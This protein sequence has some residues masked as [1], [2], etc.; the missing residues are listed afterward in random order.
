MLAKHQFPESQYQEYADQGYTILRGLI[1]KEQA[2]LLRQE[3]LDVV[4]ARNMPDSYLAQSHEYLVGSALDELNNGPELRKVVSDFMGG[5]S[6]LYLPFT[7]VKGAHQGPF[8]FH[9]D[10]QYTRHDG[11][12]CNCWIA[13]GPCTEAN[14]TLQVVPGSHK[15]G[16]YESKAM[17]VD[18]DGNES[19][20]TMA[21]E[22]TDW[23]DV[24][25]EPGDAILF[26]RLTVH[27]SSANETDEP[28]IAYAVQFHRN[29]TKWLDKEDD[30][31]KLLKED[32]RWDIAPVEKFSALAQVGE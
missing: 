9:Q 3:V 1:S 8:L 26:D 21:E 6:S 13:F 20:R 7:A 23:V 24:E 30:T 17:F 16:V 31:W 29:D 12:S 28:R 5:D 22:V 15:H 10:N 32:Q 18:E 11:K 14:G 4:A 2:A 19:H 27:G 25:L